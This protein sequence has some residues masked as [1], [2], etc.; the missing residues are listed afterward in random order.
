MSERSPLPKTLQKPAKGRVLMFA[1]HADDDVIGCGGTLAQ[2]AEQGDAVRI[3]VAY[4]G[5][6]GD[7]KQLHEPEAYV[8]QR[9]AEAL[10]AG[11]HLGLSDYEFWDYPEGHEPA[12]DQMLAAA[13]C[14]VAE[15]ERQRP[16]L[17]YAPWVGEQHVDHHVLGR[18]VRLGL[19]LAQFKGLAFGYEVWTP[20][21]PTLIVN[22]SGWY[23]AKQAALAEHVS[24]QAEIAHMDHKDLAISAQRAM[25]L[26]PDDLHGEGFCELGPVAGD[27]RKLLE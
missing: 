18:V 4:D 21:V 23:A 13:K 17:V 19:A 26:N 16:D 27:D 6:R 1:P 14:V 3:V 20:L 22:I 5:R 15:I 8:A 7:S 11:A 10:R 25:Y 2:H 24:Q 9:R 12:P